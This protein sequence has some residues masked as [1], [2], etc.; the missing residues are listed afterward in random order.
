MLWA[1]NGLCMSYSHVAPALRCKKGLRLR[2]SQTQPL[3]LQAQNC[4]RTGVSRS[5]YCAQ[6]RWSTSCVA[7]RLRGLKLSD[8]IREI[9]R[10]AYEGSGGDALSAEVAGSSIEDARTIF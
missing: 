4:A 7:Y 5:P 8:K 1:Q 9:L 2:N 3:V 10:L 6:N